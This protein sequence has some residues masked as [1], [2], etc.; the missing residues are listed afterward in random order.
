M[1]YFFNDRDAPSV[2]REPR[3]ALTSWR[4]VETAI[5]DRHILMRLHGD[6]IRVSTALVQID[7]TARTA[8]TASGRF[9][10]FLG[11]PEEALWFR[12]AFEANA[13]RLGLRQI[14]DV[15]DVLW[16]TLRASEH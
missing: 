6:R 10:E 2:A 13:Y 12:V 11:P 7:S 9:Y 15:S 14:V 1:I 16:A 3:S 5:G 8:T 4:I